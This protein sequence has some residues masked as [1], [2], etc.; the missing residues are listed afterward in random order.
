MSWLEFIS[1]MSS[2]L[3]WPVV[4]A[5]AIILL[6]TQ[7]KEV[8]AALAK[9]VRDIRRVKAAGVDIELE[10]QMQGIAATTAAATLD[11]R[12]ETPNALPLAQPED[13]LMPP[14]TADER[15]SK[16]QHLALLDPRAAI[17]LPFSDL[18]RAIRQRV[19]QLYPQE[20]SNLSFARIVDILHRDGKLDDDIAGALRQMS[21]IRNQVA[22]EQ[23]ELD[24]DIANYFVDSV[25]NVT[26]YLQLSG[27]F[28]DPKPED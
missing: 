6:R 4:A 1:Q 19:H 5:G 3:A 17:I 9:K 26:G 11:L 23:A 20:R 16:Y 15:L 8:V 27:F 10:Q 22:H 13:V 18:E 24:L 21:K 28:D 25:G 7:I 12:A 2:A 14:E